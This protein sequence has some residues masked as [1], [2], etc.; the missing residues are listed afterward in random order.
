VPG[1]TNVAIKEGIFHL[2]PTDTMSWGID[3]DIDYSRNF[4]IDISAK[5]DSKKFSSRGIF[6]WADECGISSASIEFTASSMH[7]QICKFQDC[8]KYKIRRKSGHQ[9]S[10]NRYVVRKVADSYYIFKNDE[11]LFAYPAEKLY[12]KRIEFA[13][14]KSHILIDY[15]RIS[16]LD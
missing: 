2:Y 4:E 7:M 10:F 16:Y 6:R 11:Y 9:D 8:G 1:Q 14:K 15:I 3:I 13:Q 5:K 12:G